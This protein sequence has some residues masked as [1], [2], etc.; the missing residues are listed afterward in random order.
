MVEAHPVA[1]L[2]RKKQF[3]V[4]RALALW[5]GQCRGRRESCLAVV[6]KKGVR[7]QDLAREGGGRGRSCS[8]TWSI[9]RDGAGERKNAAGECCAGLIEADGLEPVD[10]AL[11][12]IRAHISGRY[13]VERRDQ[14][15][16]G[17]DVEGGARDAGPD[18]E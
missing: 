4:V 5:S 13:L 14:A 16:I 10:V 17:S 1:E 3:E 9:G 18:T 8:C 12:V 11:C 15:G 7:I 2:M 6:A